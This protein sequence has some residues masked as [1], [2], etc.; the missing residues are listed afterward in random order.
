M[1]RGE[2][3]SSEWTLATGGWCP[4]G[5]LVAVATEPAPCLW[6]VGK[7]C[8]TSPPALFPHS[9]RCFLAPLLLWT[10]LQLS[11][12]AL[13]CVPNGIAFCCVSSET[14]MMCAHR[15]VWDTVRRSPGLWAHWNLFTV[16]A[17]LRRLRL[18]AEQAAVSFVWLWT[19][20]LT[21]FP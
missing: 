14:L 19:L 9:S 17:S 15:K 18:A 3:T 13:L 4:L 12:G 20:T 6:M 11:H 21:T 10:T 8:W 1:E 7:G 16:L 2:Q 5:S